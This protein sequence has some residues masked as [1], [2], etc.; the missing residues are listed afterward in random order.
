[1]QLSRF[2]L[3]HITDEQGLSL[4]DPE[5]FNYPEKVLQFGTGVFIRGLIDYYI[6]H[7]NNLHG[8]KG[9]VV[10]VKS[11]TAGNVE[12]FSRQDN[13]YT[14]IM[15]SVKDGAKLEKRVVC[16]AISRTID[17]VSDWDRV[18]ACA[19]N[20]ELKIIISNTTE[21]GITLI[22]HDSVFAMPPVSFPAKLLS[23]L[24]ARYKAFNGS[25]TSGMVIIP[26]E[27]IPDNATILKGI[28]NVQAAQNQLE[29][30]FIQWLNEHNEFCNSLVDRIVPGKLPR[31]EESVV[32]QELGYDDDLMIM[33]ETFDLWAI[34][35]ANEKTQSL[36][37]FSKENPGIHIVP[38][39]DKFR[40][41]K[42]R[43]LNGSH[44]LSC[45]IG[46]LAGFKTVKE[47]MADKEF[48][49]F[50]QRLINEEIAGAITSPKISL[51]DARNFGSQVLER[52]R[53]PYI[54]FDWLDICV[55][56]TSKIR[57]RAVPIVIQ[58]FEKHG[59]VPDAICLGFAAYILFM[60]G[61]QDGNGNFHGSYREKKYRITDD[62][63]G[64]LSDKWETLNGLDL[65]RLV[66]EDQELWGTNLALLKGLTTRVGFFLD[67]LIS[68][69][70]MYCIKSINP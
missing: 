22:D 63:A 47:A 9:R 14:L 8:F 59:Y 35:T 15:K 28:I 19:T 41:L 18:L 46:F 62:F 50:M 20:P 60:R 11:T 54:A 42:L 66:L 12:T 38:N 36:L 1:M 51:E 61:A 45:A 2:N 26:T 25:P 16:A 32:Q 3:Q 65:V 33:S 21:A 30:A 6:D 48:D 5:V 13:L 43:L 34:E 70:A 44:N 56:D 52:Y 4:P 69:G 68:Y 29:P 67:N 53:N 39:I 40:E 10:M 64:K 37:S 57:I 23:F 58:H 49:S 7:S 55:Q 17:A 31:A 24:L 27:L